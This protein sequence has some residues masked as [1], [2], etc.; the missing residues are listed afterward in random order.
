MSL[1]ITLLQ[2][3]FI[4]TL[5]PPENKSTKVFIFS[6]KNSINCGNNLYFPPI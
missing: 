1:H 6:G 2:S 5:N 4:P 3:T